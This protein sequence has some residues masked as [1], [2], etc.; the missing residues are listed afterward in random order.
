MQVVFYY[1][2]RWMLVTKP[3]AYPT[4]TNSM[5]TK[6]VTEP[7]KSIKSKLGTLLGLSY[8]ML[9]DKKIAKP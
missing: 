9:R 5:N 6:S 1:L 8:L 2:Q 7:S 3:L 4:G